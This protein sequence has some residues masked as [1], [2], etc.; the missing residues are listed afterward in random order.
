MWMT[1]RRCGLT[2]SSAVCVAFK[3]RV[4]FST[5]SSGQED[6]Q[7]TKI[8]RIRIQNRFSCRTKKNF[9][10]LK[11]E[12]LRVKKILTL[13]CSVLPELSQETLLPVCCR[14]DGHRLHHFAWRPETTWWGSAHL[15]WLPTDQTPAQKSPSGQL[16]RGFP[17]RRPRC[18]YHHRLQHRLVA[19]TQLCA[20]WPSQF[21]LGHKLRDAET[22][23]TPHTCKLP[24]LCFA[25]LPTP[26]TTPNDQPRW[27]NILHL[28]LLSTR[29]R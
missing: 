17:P 9:C 6:L 4:L 28:G 16:G 11:P 18:G 22:S 10:D 21:L 20:W 23:Q 25:V 13:L 8:H 29:D 26:W 5:I 2:I 24:L 14:S 15:Q 27:K 3:M 19:N 1:Y 7:N 12:W